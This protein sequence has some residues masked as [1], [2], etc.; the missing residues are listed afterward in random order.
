LYVL[1]A[2]ERPL[3]VG[4]PGELFIGGDGVAREYWQRPD[5]TAERF[6]PDPFVSRPGA[7]IYRTGDLAKWRP[8]GRIDFLGRADNQLKIRGYRIEL[9]EIEAAL[10]EQP[11]IRQAV[12]M[13]RE[14]T[15]ADVRLVAYLLS[16]ATISPAALRTALAAK[17]P[18]F[19]VPAHYI[20]V[21]AFPL[22]PN[23]KVDRKALPKPV[24]AAPADRVAQAPNTAAR[25]AN[26]PAP[27]GNVEEQIAAVW[28]G[29]LG[30]SQI[31]PKDNFFSLG[32]H[33]LLAVQVHRDLKAIF[34][35]AKLSIT[36][37]FR[38]PTL[39]ALSQHL[40]PDQPVSGAKDAEPGVQQTTNAAGQN[41]VQMR[42]DALSRRREM[43]AR[44]KEPT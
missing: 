42:A 19:M 4:V 44:R 31:T 25:P 12:V 3:P 21:D 43:R 13:A 33:S 8:D 30:V 32:G 15:P 22:T 6:R 39:G 40:A 10:E 38:F 7:R 37:I 1:D 24:K 34:G 36:D 5:L 41:R 28:R 18:D 9:G 11:A 23:K 27:S 17:L 16:D 20:Q 26:A 14:D 35:P 2:D 29:V